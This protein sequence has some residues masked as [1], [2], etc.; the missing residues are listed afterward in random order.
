MWLNS[1]R[2]ISIAGAFVV[3]SS[4]LGAQTRTGAAQPKEPDHPEVTAVRF[5]GVNAVD[6]VDLRTAILTDPSRCK[7][8][9]LKP[10]CWI[11]KSRVVYERNYLDRVQL[12]RDVFN[13]RVFYWKRGYREAQ[14]D[15]TVERK[16]ADRVAITFKITEGRPTVVGEVQVVQRDSVLTT[17]EWRRRMLLKPEEPL[18]LLRLDSSRVFLQT[19]LLDLGYGDAEVDT[20]IALDTAARRATVRL[21]LNPKYKTYVGGI[22]ITRGGEKKEVSDGVILRSLSFKEKDLLKRGDLLESQRSLYESNMFRRATVLP[23]LGDTTKTVE[24]SVIE[25]PLHDYRLSA[26]FNTI[27]FGQVEGRFTIYNWLGGAR[28]LEFQASLGNLL[29]STLNGRGIFQ[30]VGSRTGGREDVFFQP[31]YKASADYRQPWFGSRVSQVAFSVFAHRLS[32]PGISVDRGFGTSLTFTRAVDRR[33]PASLNYRYE[34][35]HVDAADVYFCVN[36]GICDQQTLESLP[37]RQRLSPLVLSTSTERT[38]DPL[39]PTSGYRAQ[40]EVEHASTYTISDY[41]YN[42]AML[43]IT[44]YIRL[45]RRGTIAGH[46]RLGWVHS[47]SSTSQALGLDDDVG[48]LPG[49]GQVVHPRRRFYAGGSRSVRGFGEN[50]LGPRVLTIPADVLRNDTIAC[51]ASIP[52]EQCDPTTSVFANRDFEPRAL[53]GNRL[54]EGSIELRFPISA[55]DLIGAVFLDGALVSQQINPTLPKRVIAATPGFGIRYKSIAGP[56]RVDIG[57]NPLVSEDL[58]VVTEKI[59]DGKRELVTL[60]KRRSYGPV[61]GSGLAGLL[62]RLT[63]H[64]SI[65]E[66]F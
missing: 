47:L 33:T 53:G 8:L 27:D 42:R 40:L 35:T 32:Q 5:R 17:R 41:R 36:F 55:P 64:L 11:S 66:A 12:K 19:H 21:I 56:I 51:A 38:N 24:I 18:N 58:P 23:I 29:A 20:A 31:T 50:Q 62:N 48:G 16:G 39:S 34:L 10:L 59:V 25:A 44:R 37:D 46:L 2:S 49:G 6:E 63:L 26:G 45:T 65:G 22:V 43:D 7:S 3:A 28:R 15:T 60:D 1:M 30:D 14:V 61:K 13:I 52:I 9:V 4:S 57:I 54:A